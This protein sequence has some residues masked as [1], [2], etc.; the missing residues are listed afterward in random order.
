M[1]QL[2]II[3][4]GGFGRE[5]YNSA[6][7]SNGYGEDF[8]IKGFIDDNIH[9]L[10]NFEG[11]PPILSTIDEYMPQPDDVFSCAIGNVKTR[12]LLSLKIIWKGGIFIT[13]IHK[14][15]YISKNVKMGNGCII[16]A[17]ARIHC[18]VTI[19]NHVIMQPYSITGHDV[20]VGDWSLLNAYADCGGGSVLGELVTLHTTSF[21]LP[22]S[23][24]ED[25]A[26]VGAGSVVL[27]KVAKGITVFG[28]P[29]K[30]VL[31]P[32]KK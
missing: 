2:I 22:L 13:L 25:E 23:V 27:R 3:G 5:V 9:K 21:I 10:D 4:A 16:L 19:G 24:L 15:A 8:L 28:V 6:I 14:L 20:K 30:P 18:D 17:G 31:T 26:T 7:E 29:A 11:Y 12:K 1:K 32:N